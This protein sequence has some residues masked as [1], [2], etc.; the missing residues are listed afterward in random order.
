MNETLKGLRVLEIYMS[1]SYLTLITDQGPRSFYVEGDCCS[2]SEFYDFYGVEF[3]LG[4]EIV[5]FEQVGL[6]PGDEG[7]RPSTWETA[8]EEEYLVTEVYG[9]R[10]TT[11]H[12]TFGPVSSVVS[13]RNTSNGY[14]GGYM[15]V[16]PNSHLTDPK[17]RIMKDTVLGD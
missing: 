6:S 14:Y 15:V 2:C 5:E 1:E 11:I 16:S 10:F 17:Y 7:Y 4:S 9:Y 12:P 3:L 13:F 8:D